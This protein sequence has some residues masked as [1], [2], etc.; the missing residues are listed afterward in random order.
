MRSTCYGSIAR[1]SARLLNV[2]ISAT[3]LS[4]S[5]RIFRTCVRLSSL[6]VLPEFLRRGLHPMPSWFSVRPPGFA[7]PRSHYYGLEM[8]AYYTYQHE[9]KEESDVSP[10]RNSRWMPGVERCRL[11]TNNAGLDSAG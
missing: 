9:F 3:R 7:V 5:A 8:R 11:C 10:Y 1:I 2:V 4:R 6:S